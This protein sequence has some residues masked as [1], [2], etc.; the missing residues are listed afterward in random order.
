V[1][2]RAP[3]GKVPCIGARVTVTIGKKKLMDEVIGVRGYLS[4]SD[5]RVHFGLG[6][7]T[8]AD[9]VEVRW[10][11]RTVQR[12]RNVRANQTLIIVKDAPVGV[13]RK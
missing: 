8:Q 10:P 9:L 6:K 1:D 2:V 7:A 13:S 3:G 11:E 4:Q 12:F 5:T